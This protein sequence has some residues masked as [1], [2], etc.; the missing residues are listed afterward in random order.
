MAYTQ[1]YGGG[2][3]DSPTT[4]TPVDSTFLNALEAAVLKVFGVDPSADGQALLWKLANSRYEPA[5]I[6]NANIDPAAAIAKSK[7]AALGIV[8][9]DVAAGANI[10]A[11]KIAGNIPI[12]K[13]AGYPGNIQT[14]VR[15]DGTFATGTQG[16]YRKTTQK[17]ISNSVAET[18]L[19]NGEVTVAA[20]AMA[21]SGVLRFTLYGVIFNS[22][23]TQ[24]AIRYKLKLG[25]TT[26]LDT[27][28]I[29]TFWGA[30]GQ[31][32][33]RIS[34][35][36]ANLGAPNAQ[37]STM[38]VEQSGNF[39]A[40]NAAFATG[41]GSYVSVVATNGL[42]EAFGTNSTAVD[43]TVANALAVTAIL[44]VANANV[45]I[46]LLGAVVELV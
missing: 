34:G 22:V 6:T 14:F 7:L 45:S 19:L 2:F 18:D 26:I 20:G 13:L 8:D 25:A 30:G 23:A 3:L 31:S 21:S 28:T 11:S 15:G 4:S 9:A 36:I 42:A 16:L 44:P 17:S 37:F 41:N 46:L 24:S 33:F 35:E 12:S 43:T 1:R 10:A 38:K 5:L 29:A 39:A 27:S 32:A 40:G